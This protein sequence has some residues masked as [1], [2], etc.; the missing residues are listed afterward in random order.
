MNKLILFLILIL[1]I[2]W[3]FQS[4]KINFNAD[5]AKQ[6]AIEAMKK[7]KTINKVNSTRDDRQQEVYDINH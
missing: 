5:S 7:E 1:V 2:G 4:G 6:S 3:L